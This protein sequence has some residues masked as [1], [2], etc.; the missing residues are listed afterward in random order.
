LFFDLSRGMRE[1]PVWPIDI[2]QPQAKDA[3]TALGY[4][5]ADAID[6]FPI[7]FYPRCLQRA[8]ENAAVVDFDLTIPQDGW[9]DI[10]YRPGI[11]QGFTPDREH[12]SAWYLRGTSGIHSAHLFIEKAPREADQKKRSDPRFSWSG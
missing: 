3:P 8:H 2:F 1:D 9:S 5:L 11:P 10:E 12:F 7:P 4:M 6:G